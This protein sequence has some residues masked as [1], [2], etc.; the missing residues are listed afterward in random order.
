MNL[1]LRLPALLIAILG[2]GAGCRSSSPSPAEPAQARETLQVVLTA[3]QNGDAVESLT[4]RTPSITANDPLWQDGARLL[5]YEIAAESKPSG[6][7]LQFRVALWLQGAS[8]KETQKNVVY[9][10]STN[11]ALVVLR[12]N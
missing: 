6:Y 3:W 8:G 9:T 1:T 4:K 11:P 12:E 2:L 5:R 10:V 7:D